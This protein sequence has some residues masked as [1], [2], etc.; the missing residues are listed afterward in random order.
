MLR[1]V[2]QTV[3]GYSELCSRQQTNVFV[4]HRPKLRMP[5]ESGQ[6]KRRAETGTRLDEP[7]KKVRL[8]NSSTCELS[9]Q[10]AVVVDSRIAPISRSKKRHRGDCEIPNPETVGGRTAKRTRICEGHN[11]MQQ[12][13]P[14]EERK[15]VSCQQLVVWLLTFIFEGTANC[16]LSGSA[17]Q[18][19]PQCIYVLNFNTRQARYSQITMV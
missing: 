17:P 15:M 4:S 6:R 19:D 14:Q 10:S 3:L 9:H 7:A 5:C 8:L 2:G 1:S 12:K 18:V 16:G 11:S 13:F